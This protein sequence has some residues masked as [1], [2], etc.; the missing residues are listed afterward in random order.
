MT[1]KNQHDPGVTSGAL[2]PSLKYLFFARWWLGTRTGNQDP[3]PRTIKTTPAAPFAAS[4]VADITK[5]KV[6]CF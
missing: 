1:L 6:F 5:I 2:L 3:G 4:A